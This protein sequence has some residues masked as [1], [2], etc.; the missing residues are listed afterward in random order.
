ML[1]E[2][3]AAALWE[4]FC[5][6]DELLA[7]ALPPN[8]LEQ[9][10][11][12]LSFD[13]LLGLARQFGPED[14]A[15][16][17]DFD[18]ESRP[19]VP[20]FTVA[21]DD[22]GGR[23]KPTTRAHQNHLQRWQEEFANGDTFLQLPKY[24]KGSASFLAAVAD[25]L[26]PYA[27]WLNAAAGHLAAIIARAFTHHRLDRGLMTF[28]DQVY[29]C[30]RLVDDP[31]VLNRLRLRGYIVIL[32]EAQD[33]DA[34]MFSIL[35]EITRPIGGVPGA[36]PTRTDAP[37]PESGRF[38]FVGDDQQAI[39][40]ERAD[41]AVYPS[42][43]RRV[44]GRERRRPPGVFRD[45]ALP[46][47]SDRSGE[48]SL[49]RRTAGPVVGEVPPARPR[50]PVAR[51]ARRGGLELGGPPS[52]E[53]R[54]NVDAR[55]THECEQIAD[56]V[57]ARG[58]AGLGV[59]RWSEVA[60]ICPRVRWLETAA[61]VFEDRGLPTYLLSQRR[62]ARA[63]AR[64]SW[65]AALLHVLVHPWDRFELI[66]VLRE[67]FAVSDVD[68]ARLHRRAGVAGQGERA[69]L[70]A[71]AA[72]RSAERG[73]VTTPAKGAGVAARGPCAD[74]GVNL[75]PVRKERLSA[76]TW[77]WCWRKTALAQRLA[78]IGEPPNVLDSLRAQAK[79]A[80][81]DGLTIR[82]WV[83]SLVDALELPVPPQ[84]GAQ[85]AVQFLTCL[86]AKG[87][88]WPVVIPLG[89]G[90]EIRERSRTYPRLERQETR[91]EIH[92]S[93]V[94]MDPDRRTAR[95]RRQAEEF[96]RMLYVTFTRAKRL[97]I[98]PDG[99][100]LYDGRA[101]NYLELARWDEL[102][103]PALFA[104]PAAQD[105]SSTVPTAE[106]SDPG[107]AI[108]R[109]EQTPPLTR[110]RDLPADPPSYPAVRP[111]S[112]QGP[113]GCPGRHAAGRGRRPPAGIGDRQR[114]RERTRS[115]PPGHRRHRVRQLVACG[116]AKLSLEL[117]VRP[118]ATAISP[119]SA[120]S[121][122]TPWTGPPGRTRNSR[123]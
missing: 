8:L 98:A 7:L 76:A 30:R 52:G 104:P 82:A 48:R 64:H 69:G 85:D 34:E 122:P 29:W 101:P 113:G 75:P 116:A 51:K 100:Q 14:T 42:L 115:I 97:L 33:T 53:G 24:E 21:L 32:D 11:R 87:L 83:R 22:D 57:R 108:F 46:A 88:E 77:I 23:S 28:Q 3:D 31:V 44:Q 1:E 60:V 81:C 50:V 62:I 89:L 79:R 15:A 103:I 9:V 13:E 71:C 54:I 2:R 12:H 39:Y 117:G 99:R 114:A 18:V 123:G 5:E 66:G 27:L 65:P 10:S 58:L 73:A 41:L 38:C 47:E 118:N 16:H 25:A 120:P 94:T 17:D 68:M 91:T 119:I 43:H 35:T 102:N 78:A 110:C 36:W 59:A 107:L 19:P 96:Q 20:D 106:S 109:G 56:F 55:L 95:A 26:K 112:F 93:S 74:A 67:I 105:T 84:P 70:L 111:R 6:S 37:G 80:E 72:G 92:F 45:D 121:S 4:R 49:R 61:R 63:E 90:C 86:K 40:G